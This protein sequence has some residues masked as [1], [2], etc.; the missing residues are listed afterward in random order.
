MALVHQCVSSS[1]GFI[2]LVVV[3]VGP[4][5]VAIVDCRCPQVKINKIKVCS[6]LPSTESYW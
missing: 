5:I 2:G 1:L 3:I 6:L 4:V